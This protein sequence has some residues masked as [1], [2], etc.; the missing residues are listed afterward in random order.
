MHVQ[1]P[2]T[3]N[4]ENVAYENRSDPCGC[5]CAWYSEE[6]YGRKHQES[7]KESYYDRDSKDLHA[8]ICTNPQKGVQCMNRMIDLSD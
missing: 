8:G 4:T 2:R 5:W 1:R 3:R 6:G 7:I